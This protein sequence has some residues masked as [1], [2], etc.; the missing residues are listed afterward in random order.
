MVTCSQK[1]SF[2]D[3]IGQVSTRKTTGGLSHTVE[4][5]GIRKFHFLGVDLQDGF[6]A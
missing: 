5:H 1:G 2:I 6:A 4:I 3:E